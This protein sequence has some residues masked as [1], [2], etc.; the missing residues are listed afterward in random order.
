MAKAVA[1]GKYLSRY[2]EQRSTTRTMC[3]F[4]KKKFFS[5]F[6]MFEMKMC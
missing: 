1:A 6:N 4:L 3:F 2:S 5:H